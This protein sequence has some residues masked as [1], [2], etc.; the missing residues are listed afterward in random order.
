[1]EDIEH[2]QHDRECFIYECEERNPLPPSPAG[3]GDSRKSDDRR[4]RDKARHIDQ[5]PRGFMEADHPTHK[6]PPHCEGPPVDYHRRKH[7]VGGMEN[8]LSGREEETHLESVNTFFERRRRL[9]GP[10]R[11]AEPGQE[12]L[13]E[14]E[15]DSGSFFY[16]L[17]ETEYRPKDQPV[18]IFSRS[19]SSSKYLQFPEAYDHFLSSSSSDDDDSSTESEEDDLGLIRVVTRFSRRTTEAQTETDIYENVFTDWGLCQNLFWNTTF[20]F[21]NFR[22]GGPVSQNQQS[23]GPLIPVDRSSVQRRRR[24][25]KSINALGNQDTEVPDPLLYHFEERVYRQLSRHPFSFDDLQSAVSHPSLGVSLVPLRQSDMCLV[26]IAFASWVLKSA[27]PQVGDAWKAV[28]LANVSALSAIRFL[29]RYMR[30]RSLDRPAI[31]L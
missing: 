19:R 20:S 28:V 30:E 29:R 25:F 5:T 2:S 27:N 1:M 6:G 16:P 22:L 13:E 15:F 17:G 24:V 12:G 26:C 8:V 21:R 31:S 9:A 7:S 4:C 3:V 14:Q 18:P 23:S 11:L 10:G